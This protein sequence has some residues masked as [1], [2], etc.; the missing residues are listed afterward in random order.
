LDPAIGLKKTERFRGAGPSPLTRHVQQERDFPHFSFLLS[1]FPN[2]NELRS[3]VGFRAW[4]GIN[5]KNE[6]A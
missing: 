4:R 2:E 6:I 3:L 1:C 5:L